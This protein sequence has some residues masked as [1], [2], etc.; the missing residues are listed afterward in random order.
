MAPVVI[1]AGVVVAVVVV[2]VVV[3]VASG[4]GDNND[5]YVV[6]LQTGATR[7]KSV[8]PASQPASEI[9]ASQ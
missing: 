4:Y 2:V 5:D 6:A 9:T 3:V 8:E 7:Q 1:G